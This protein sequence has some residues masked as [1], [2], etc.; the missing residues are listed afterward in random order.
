MGAALALGLPA[1]GYLDVAFR[2]PYV[3]SLP[4]TEI[5]GLLANALAVMAYSIPML[6]LLFP[7]VPRRRRVGDGSSGCGSPGRC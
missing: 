2:E 5:A 1:E 6:F 4:G 7:P 3:A